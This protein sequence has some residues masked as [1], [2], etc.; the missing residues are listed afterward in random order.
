[1]IKLKN[2]CQDGTILVTKSIQKAIDQ[3]AMDGGYLVIPAGKYL[4]GS[5]FL[6]S[7]FCLKLE[8]GAV[9]L[10]SKKLKDYIKI[11]TRIAGIDMIWPAAILNV[12]RATDVKII[13]PGTIDGQG[14]YW[15]DRFW[16]TDQKSGMMGQYQQRGLRWAVDYDCQRPRNIVVARSHNVSIMNLVSLDSGF[17]NTQIVYSK[18]IL[19]VDCKIKNSAGPSTDGIDIDSSCKVIIRNCMVES[20]D[21]NICLKSGRG[22]EAEQQHT[23]CEQILIEDCQ[24]G[25]GSGITFGSET[26]GGI[27]DV[28]IR[29]V[30]FNGTSVGLR[31][32][33]AINRGGFVKRIDVSQLRMNNVRYSFLFQTNWYPDYSYCKI[34]KN[35]QGVIPMYWNQLRQ[36]VQGFKGLTFVDNITITDVVSKT[37]S[38]VL[39]RAF[40]IQA[41]SSRPI[42][43]LKFKN[44]NIIASEFGK[45][46]GVKDLVWDNVNLTTLKETLKE[47]DTFDR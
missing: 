17:W 2:I 16:G 40:F 23:R 35:Y 25:S 21:D 27:S 33:S 11:N 5:L 14:A 39:S 26:S 46:A 36:D 28:I 1:M 4:V 22:R 44:I 3:A 24:L 12:N 41:S 47:N 42:N 30:E 18:N 10:G 29:R 15:W 32:K 37:T 9:L 38:D 34:P 13:G 31:L 6:P 45:I 19:L 20:N 43:R 8:A 7:H